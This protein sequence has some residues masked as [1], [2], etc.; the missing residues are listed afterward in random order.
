MRLLSFTHS[1][2]EDWH[3][4]CDYAWVDL[5]P[6]LAKVILAKVKQFKEQRAKDTTLRSMDYRDDS[7]IF[8][9]TLT[10]EQESQVDPALYDDEFIEV[11]FSLDYD[12]HTRMD[13]I[14]LVIEELGAYWEGGPHYGGVIVET[15]RITIEQL[16][17][18]AGKEEYDEQNQDTTNAA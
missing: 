16:R 12:K 3:G 4:A 9:D 15:R 11:D 7:V 1:S 10:D 13:Y 18:A 8:T 5:T 2:I 17:K 14:R 6:E